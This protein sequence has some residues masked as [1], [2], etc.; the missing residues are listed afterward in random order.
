MEDKAL[1]FGDCH[2][3]SFPFCEL[4]SL[5]GTNLFGSD[6]Q[7]PLCLCARSGSHGDTWGPPGSAWCKTWWW[8]PSLAPTLIAE[9]QKGFLE[10]DTAENSSGWQ[11]FNS[12][13]SG[14]SSQVM[15]LSGWKHSGQHHCFWVECNN[16]PPSLLPVYQMC[17]QHSQ[18]KD[19]RWINQHIRLIRGGGWTQT[20]CGPRNSAGSPF[21][22][23]LFSCRARRRGQPCSLTLWGLAQHCGSSTRLSATQLGSKACFIARPEIRGGQDQRGGVSLGWWTRTW[24]NRN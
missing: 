5:R 6:N 24:G 18:R 10:T 20:P 17:E 2:A 19:W 11:R 12:K 7:V 8:A 22:L 23:A 16:F 13:R 15:F 21:G 9:E 1:H 14:K 3:Q 4:V